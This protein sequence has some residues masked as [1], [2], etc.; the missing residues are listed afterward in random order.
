MQLT[1][2]KLRKY[3]H[4]LI[5]YNALKLLIDIMKQAKKDIK[6]IKKNVLRILFHD[7]KDTAE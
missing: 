4:D 1:R 2:I 6:Y 5:N 7:T 3:E